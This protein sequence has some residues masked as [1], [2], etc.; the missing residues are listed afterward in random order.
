MSLVG[1]GFI[2]DVSSA[3]EKADRIRAKRKNAYD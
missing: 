1:H 3:I 2:P